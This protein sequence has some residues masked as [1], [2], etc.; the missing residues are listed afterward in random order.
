MLVA[1]GDIENHFP[2][3]ET[4]G[5]LQQPPQ[6]YTKVLYL[7]QNQTKTG[8]IFFYALDL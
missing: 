8:Q 5:T 7:P 2:T 6:K 1:A 4:Y 3:Y